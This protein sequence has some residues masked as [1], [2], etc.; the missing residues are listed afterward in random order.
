MANGQ[1]GKNNNSLN[2]IV[3]NDSLPELETAEIAEQEPVELPKL[4]QIGEP[5]KF[6]FISW[7]SLGGNLAWKIKKAGHEVKFWHKDKEDIE[8]YDGFID[9]VD[10]WEDFKNWA[11]VIIFDDSGFGK[12]ADSL[13]REGKLVVGPTEYSDKL[14]EDREFGQSEMKRVGMLTLPHWNFFDYEEA[15]D[16]LKK[17]PGRYVFKPSGTVL[18]DQKGILFIGNDDSGSD[19]IELLVQNKNTWSKKYKK[20]QLQK[21]VQG[22]EIAVGVFFNGND[23]IYPININFEH[24]KLFPGDIGPYTPE[25]GTLMF[26]SGPNTIF[27][28]TLEKIKESLKDS[29]YVGYVDIN[30]IAN[31]RGIYPLE[32]T[33]RFGYPTISVQMEGVISEWGEF[34]YK[35]A[36]GEQFELRT[37]RG[38]QIGI[39]VAVP[40]FPYDDKKAFEIYRDLSITFKKSNLE[41][42]HL[43]DVK[44]LDN[45]WHLAG[46]SGYALIIT[47][48]GFTVAEARKMAYNRVEN[49]LLQNKFYRTDIG[50]RW[51]SDSDKLQSWGYLT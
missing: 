5:K 37:K 17:N 23:F 8:I 43:G 41:G 22:V 44:L 51:N 18:S 48:G 11:D 14:E 27:K 12:I 20:I 47:G 28:M 26:W 40:P 9:K 45:A 2:E 30:C 24:K 16:F 36:K 4:E 46:D 33:C 29:K 25:M 13:R 10:R 31:G 32:F 21:F 19:L 35:I 39:V 6:L 50:I 38:F 42:V 3:E 7:E 49:I 1:N 15:I 34:L